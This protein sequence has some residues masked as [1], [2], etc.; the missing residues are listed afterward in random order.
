MSSTF[1]LLF[2][3]LSCIALLVGGKYWLGDISDD[4]MDDIDESYLKFTR[5]NFTSLKD[6]PED[7][8]VDPESQLTEEDLKVFENE[9]LFSDDDANITLA[10]EKDL[11]LDKESLQFQSSGGL[12]DDEIEFLT[13]DDPL[14]EKAKLAQVADRNSIYK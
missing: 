13:S 2:L 5:N 7:F 10:S 3:Y 6:I 8:P 14:G 12:N 1:S 9:D 11:G 4:V